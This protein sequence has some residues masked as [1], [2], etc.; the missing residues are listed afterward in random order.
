MDESQFI[1]QL[2]VPRESVPSP[3][4]EVTTSDM[5]PRLDTFL[6]SRLPTVP[7]REILEWI[8]T[9][10]VRVNAQ[11]GRKGDRLHPGDHVA[12]LAPTILPANPQ[13]TIRIVFTDEALVVLDKPAGM[14]SVALRHDE[15]NTVPNFLLA[16]FPETATV[17]PRSLEAG[18]VHRLDTATSGL[19][20]VART[21]YTY[22]AL[23]KA[24]TSHVV[25][26]HYVVFVEGQLR[27]SGQRTSDLAAAGK[28]GQRM[29]EVAD[30]KG[31]RACTIYTPLERF[32]RHTLV[33]V[34]IPTGVRHQIRV[35]LA[36]LGHPIVGDTLYGG[37]LEYAARLCLHATTLAF[38]H[39]LT[40][41]RVRFES[42]LPEDFREE[43]TVTNDKGA[44][45]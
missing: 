35:H 4:W 9:R 2:S 23:R 39:P 26:K 37:S 8:V 43:G 19:L 45:T 16:H 17:S 12:L 7:K 6:Q 11:V 36:A 41:K 25:E 15:T 34:T 3:Q 30:G 28:R 5:T 22:I 40:G 10:R 29:R 13:L 38:P 31:Q 1:G 33:H 24:F 21:P 32:P 42:P 27:R 44:I 18:V 20:L 14:P